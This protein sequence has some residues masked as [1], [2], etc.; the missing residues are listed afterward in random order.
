MPANFLHGVETIEITTGANPIVVV[1]TAVIGIVGTAPIY[2]CDPANQTTNTPVLILNDQSAAASFGVDTPGY[3]I[4]SAINAVLDQ[5]VNGQG[6][7]AMIVVNVFDPTIHKTAVASQP[8]A[9][10]SAG[11]LA[12][13]YPGVSSVVVKSS[14]GETTYVAGTDYS[15]D[16]VNGILSIVTGG[17]IAAGATVEVSFDYAD[18]S[19]VQTSDIIGATD[20]SGNR[21]GLQALLNSFGLFGFNPKILIAPGFS[22]LASVAAAMDVVAQA[23]RAVEL[24]DAPIGTTFQ[25]VLAGRGPS[26]D[27]AFDTSSERAILCYPYVSAFDTATNAD[28]LQPFSQWLAG[29][30]AATDLAFGYWYSPSNKQIQG[31]DGVERILTSMINDPNSEVNQLNSVGI[32][33]IMNYYG[34]GLRSW[35]NR[36]AAWP[37]ET[38]P[39]NFISI[40]R[41]ADV[42]E[43]SIEYSSLQRLDQPITNAWISQVCEDVNSFFRTRVGQGALIDGKCWYDPTLNQPSELALG[44]IVFSYSFMPPPPAERITF[45]SLVDINYLNEL[46][47]PSVS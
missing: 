19:K 30:I 9:F 1:K 2:Q 29:L 22:Q 24:V 13:G 16:A 46:G 28:E 11:T 40:R 12:L 31:I 42:I 32:V 18:P 45:Q 15:L 21:T 43:D 47:T 14:N 44:H 37:T 17:A 33:T 3:T 23:I 34:T 6:A 41:T 8:L 26:G 4:P 27:I 36:S 5:Q 38:A 39:K 7:G 35:G 20:V 10:A 25:Q